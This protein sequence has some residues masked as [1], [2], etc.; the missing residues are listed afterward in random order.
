MVFLLHL[1]LSENR[2][3]LP[4]RVPQKQEAFENNEME[5]REMNSSVIEA[6]LALVGGLSVMMSAVWILSAST[7]KPDIHQKTVETAGEENE[8]ATIRKAA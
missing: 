2:K 6:T 4:G 8:S 7:S 3:I 1:F 5:G